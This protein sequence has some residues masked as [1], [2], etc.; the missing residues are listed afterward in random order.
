M[1][2]Q[3]TTSG[4]AP[5]APDAGGSVACGTMLREAR[6]AAGL[7]IE[8]IA[9]QLKLHPRQVKALEEGQFE[10][11]PGRTFVRGFLRNYARALNLDADQLLAALPDTRAPQALEPTAHSMGEIR[12]EESPRRAWSRWTIPLALIVLV[13]LAAVYEYLRPAGD[14]R[15]SADTRPAPAAS[16]PPL[17]STPQAPAAEPQGG[18]PLPNPL[19]VAAPDAATGSEAPPPG[20]SAPATSPTPGPATGIVSTA[21]PPTAPGEPTLVIVY[22]G[23]S[24]TEVRDG[25]GKVLLSLTGSPGM[26]QSVSGRPPFDVVIGSVADV[27]LR[28]RGAPVDLAPYRR[29]NVARLRLD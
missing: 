20:V 17:P 16:Q 29:A 5:E 7:S 11:L 24:W 22:T 6:E 18:T 25:T 3:P 12:F 1:I 23:A 27:S 13:A 2:E 4:G 26:T 19:A 21:I 14:S 8:A 15:R 9:Q 10:L 28:F